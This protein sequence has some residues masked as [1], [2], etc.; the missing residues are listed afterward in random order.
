MD[1]LPTEF[2]HSGSIL[3]RMDADLIVS[4][5]KL[6]KAGTIQLGIVKQLLVLL[7]SPG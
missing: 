2:E 6:R 1:S 3:R 4:K 5:Q 7:F